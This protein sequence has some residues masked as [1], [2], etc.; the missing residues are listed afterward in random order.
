M[1]FMSQP[2]I[3]VTGTD[4]AQTEGMNLTAQEGI[5]VQIKINNSF[6]K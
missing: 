2:E 6:R 3:C 1:T 4:I 5:I